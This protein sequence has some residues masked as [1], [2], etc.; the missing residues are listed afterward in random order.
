[1]AGVNLVQQ[2]T[3]GRK[4]RRPAHPFI[5][6][7]VPFVIQ[8]TGI[9][10]VLPGETLKQAM[11]QCRAVTDPIKNGLIGWWLETYLFYVKLRDLDDRDEFTSMI[12]EP[13]W[14]NANVDDTT[15]RLPTYHGG[16]GIDYVK[17]CLTRVTDEYFRDE[18]ETW[19]DHVV[20]CQGQDM[21]IAAIDNKSWL[22][23]AVLDDARDATDVAVQLDNTDT[24]PGPDQLMY[25]SIENAR[26]Q[27]ETA[28]SM[29]LM[30]MSFEEYCAAYGVKMDEKLD[31]HRPEL[32]RYAREWQ[33]PSNTI[34]PA[35]GSAVAAVSWAMSERADK[36]RFFREPGFLCSYMV[37]RPKVYYR[38]Q[39]GAAVNAMDNNRMWLPAMALNDPQ[40]G[41]RFFAEGAG[42]IQASLTGTEGYWLDIRDL[43]MYGDQFTNFDP[44]A[45][46][47][48]MIP[49]PSADLESAYA[50][51]LDS[52]KEFFVTGATDFYVE[53][54]G[55]WTYQI[56]SQ[57][58]D[59]SPTRNAALTF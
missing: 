14:S 33:Y 26:L 10:P 46:D 49:L 59:Y 38:N 12:L 18:G 37:A 45:T 17:K 34:D 27:W 57:V 8:P 25:S 28:Q 42:P 5:V 44:A 30:T 16:D 52:I 6:R 24:V 36:E 23:S 54:D 43:M 40:I 1:M 21:P 20:A 7:T 58:R 53:I 55:I 22:D 41:W 31:P 48:N 35:D 47:A 9:A 11:F 2:P 32:L 51:T 3:M 15:A 50:P 56:A 13:T 39:A 4:I 29:G 19:D